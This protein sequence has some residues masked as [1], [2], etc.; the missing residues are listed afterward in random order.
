M[1]PW[2][3]NPWDMSIMTSAIFT[4]GSGVWSGPAGHLDKV[5]GKDEGEDLRKV[6][7]RSA[8]VE[9]WSTSQYHTSTYAKIEDPTTPWPE[10]RLVN[11][12]TSASAKTRLK[13][14]INNKICWNNLAEWVC[15]AFPTHL[16]NRLYKTCKLSTST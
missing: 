6:A 1:K 10:G 12:E 16:N 5:N 11:L 14:L 3:Y 4:Q 2:R 8:E 15:S 9:V 13:R 7:N